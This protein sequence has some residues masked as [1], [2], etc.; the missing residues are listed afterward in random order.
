MSDP[1]RAWLSQI[2]AED[3]CVALMPLGL[4]ALT[5][6]G[7]LGF[8][9]LESDPDA[10]ARLE[11]ELVRVIGEGSPAAIIYSA[12]LLRIIGRDVQALLTPYTDDQRACTIMPFELVPGIHTLCEAVQWVITSE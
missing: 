7:Y 1:E 11:P 4:R 6:N 5:T 8:R 9:A 12:L 2:E 3:D 10:I